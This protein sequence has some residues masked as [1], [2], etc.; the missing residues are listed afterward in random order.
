MPAVLLFGDLPTLQTRM[1]R[2]MA[3]IQFLA[4]AAFNPL[5]WRSATLPWNLFVTDA[6]ET[7]IS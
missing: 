4:P 1:Q 6:P 2:L 5:L 3:T 7:P